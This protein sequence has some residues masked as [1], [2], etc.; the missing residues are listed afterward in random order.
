MYIY[1]Y[2]KFPHVWNYSTE[3]KNQ[4]TRNLNLKEVLWQDLNP[5]EMIY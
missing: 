5:R 1:Y 4:I 3:Q 2:V